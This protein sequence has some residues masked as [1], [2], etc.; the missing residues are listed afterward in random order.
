MMAVILGTMTLGIAY[1]A[2]HLHPVFQEGGDT[3]LSQLGDSIFGTDSVHVLR[4]AV[5]DVRDPDPRRQHRVQRV[6]P[7]VVEHRQRRLPP[8]TARQ[9]G[10]SAGVLER[11]PDPVGHGRRA[12]RGLPG[13]RQRADPALRRRRVRRV[14]AQPGRHGATPPPPEGGGLAQEPGDQPARL[15]DDRHRADRRRRVEVHR[16]RVDPGRR[17]PA[18][19]GAP[20]RDQQA[21]PDDGPPAPDAAGGEGAPPHQ[22]RDRARRPDHA[23]LDDGARLRP[24][25]APRPAGRAV[26]RGQRRGAGA[27]RAGLGGAS[28]PG[29]A[30]DPLLA[31][32]R[33]VPTRSCGTSTSWTAPTTTTS[34]P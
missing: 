15:R 9:P 29:R 28:D 20:P 3:V 12:D 24:F 1:L 26:G 7:A 13:R 21:L 32:P 34:S 22:H 18:D 33:A 25:A 4:A 16:G 27:H 17:D 19:R 31:V 6:P 10:R 5:R 14:H 8:E 30:G 23:R 11:R 2:S